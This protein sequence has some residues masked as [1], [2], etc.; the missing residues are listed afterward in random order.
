VNWQDAVARARGVDCVPVKA[1][2]TMYIIYSSRTTGLPKGIQ[3]PIAGQIVCLHWSM[4]NV[5]GISPE[6]VWWCA[7]DLGWVVGHCYICYAPLL[8]GNTSVIYE[9]KPVGTPDAGALWR[10]LS[11]HKVAGLFTSPTFMR[12]IR[13]EDPK[14]ALGKKSQPGKPE[15]NL[16]RR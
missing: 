7:S 12:T 9:G 6:D 11:Q 15:A 5:Y 13:R 8:T 3:R 10:V 14:A 4:E 2:D 16:R 1:T